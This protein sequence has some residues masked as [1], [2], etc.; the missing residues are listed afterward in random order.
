MSSKQR[1]PTLNLDGFGNFSKLAKFLARQIS[2]YMIQTF[3]KKFYKR[4]LADVEWLNECT[5]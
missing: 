4:N 2:S 3:I 1:T 5:G